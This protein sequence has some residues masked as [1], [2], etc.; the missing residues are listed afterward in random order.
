MRGGVGGLLV[1]LLVGVVLGRRSGERESVSS[2][3]AGSGVVDAA[4]ASN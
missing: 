1:G 4:V 3:A 2:V